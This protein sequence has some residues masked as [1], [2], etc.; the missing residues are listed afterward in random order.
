[1]AELHNFHSRQGESVSEIISRFTIIVETARD[2]A[3]QTM[4]TEAYT[5]NLLRALDINE[6][7]L[8]NLLQPFGG[9]FPQNDAE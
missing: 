6:T 1:M 2:E 7:Q 9:I 8:M 4:S 3:G 5:W